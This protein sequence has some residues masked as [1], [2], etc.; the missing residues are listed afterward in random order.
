[1]VAPTSILKFMETS[2][3]LLLDLLKLLKDAAENTLYDKFEAAKAQQYLDKMLGFVNGA[4]QD[5]VFI[6]DVISC[7]LDFNLEF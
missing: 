5:F 3:K 4:P 6:F 7:Q 2:A 1:M